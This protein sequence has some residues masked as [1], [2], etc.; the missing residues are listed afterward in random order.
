MFVYYQDA[1][2]YFS[3]KSAIFSTQEFDAYLKSV[4]ADPQILKVGHDCKKLLRALIPSGIIPS[5]FDFDV[6]IAAYLINASRAQFG[7]VDLAWEY[8]QKNIDVTALTPAQAVLLIERLHAKMAAELEKNG[9]V[10]LFKTIE[11]PLVS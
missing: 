8:E 11:M 4:I 5:G 10:E 9:L 6:M 1:V 3:C 2:W 7:L